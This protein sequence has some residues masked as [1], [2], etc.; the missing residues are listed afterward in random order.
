[1]KEFNSVKGSLKGGLKRTKFIGWDCWLENAETG[2]LMERIS[3]IVWA[4]AIVEEVSA[5]S[6]RWTTTVSSAQLVCTGRLYANVYSTRK[7]FQRL[8]KCHR[9]DYN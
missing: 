5:Y 7:V 2:H 9:G 4:D 1:M 6:D 3:G 8:D